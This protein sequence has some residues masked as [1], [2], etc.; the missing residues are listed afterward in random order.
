M[1]IDQIQIEI[2]RLTPG[3]K[4]RVLELLAADLADR[5]PGI[6]RTSGVSGGSACISRTRIPVW[7]LEGYRRLGWSE[8]QILDNFPTVRAVDLANAW[9]YAAAH[10]EEIEMELRQNEA[11]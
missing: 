8:A 3:E 7:T 11:A 10:M 2:Q 5:W 1:T 9:A 4:A 6:D